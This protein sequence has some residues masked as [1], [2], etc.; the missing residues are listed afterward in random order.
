MTKRTSASYSAQPQSCE[1]PVVGEHHANKEGIVM[2]KVTIAPVAEEDA[3]QSHADFTGQE[4]RVNSGSDDFSGVEADSTRQDQL[5]NTQNDSGLYI[6]DLVNPDTNINTDGNNGSSPNPAPVAKPRRIAIAESYEPSKYPEMGDEQVIGDPCEPPRGCLPK[7]YDDIIDEISNVLDTSRGVAMGAHL[8]WLTGS[9]GGQAVVS[10]K[11]SCPQP[12]VLW[13]G[14]SEAS[15]GGKTAAIN[16]FMRHLQALDAEIMQSYH[17]EVRDYEAKCEKLKRSERPSPPARPGFRLVGD[18][19]LAGLAK[20]FRASPHGLMSMHD[21]LMTLFKSLKTGSSKGGTVATDFLL[22]FYDGG[23]WHRDRSDW[24][25]CV[26]E[27]QCYLMMCGGIQP[28]RLFNALSRDTLFSGF[29]GRFTLIRSIR[30][31]MPT[32]STKEI[33]K[34]TFDL[35]KEQTKY[36]STLVARL[37]GTGKKQ[38]VVK[39]DET[40]LHE[41]WTPWYNKLQEFVWRT[42]PEHQGLA[43]KQSIQASRV[44]LLLHLAEQILVQKNGMPSLT[45]SPDTLAR[46]LKLCDWLNVHKFEVWDMITGKTEGNPTFVAKHNDMKIAKAIIDHI[47]DVRAA[48]GVIP[49]RTLA[50]WVA[51]TGLQIAPVALGRACGRLEIPHTKSGVRGVRITDATFRVLYKRFRQSSMGIV[52]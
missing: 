50:A 52:A 3:I 47:D 43:M 48:D 9:I 25:N 17:V 4:S 21:E 27:K 5:E 35:L 14:I 22:Q 26:H 46:S 23:S 29:L 19:S 8:G 15:G 40:A 31:S 37:I 30:K 16:I 33:S 20:A 2:E 32:W 24:R 39:V 7:E 41:I 44:T 28:E 1:N 12:G 13:V 6:P 49:N 10:F 36:L 51:E 11:E 45:I 34:E 18:F 42:Y 38:L